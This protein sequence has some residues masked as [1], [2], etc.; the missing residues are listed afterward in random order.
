MLSDSE[1]R[2]VLISDRQRHLFAETDHLSICLDSD[3]SLFIKESSEVPDVAVSPRDLAYV[4]YT[5][6]STG[7][8]KGVMVTHGGLVN[9]VTWAAT[10]YSAGIGDSVPVHSSIAFDL[11]VTALWVPL[12]A[13]GRVELLADDVGGL[14]LLEALRRK[15]GRSLVKIT[16]AHLALLAE[17]LGPS[18]ASDLTNV[19]VIGGENLRAESLQRWR[20]E[21]PNTRLINEYG[22]TETVVGCCLYEVRRDDPRHGS[23]PIGRPI[24]NTQLYVLDSQMNPVPPG[25]MGELYIGG[26]GVARG[27]WNRRDLTEKKFVPDPFSGDTTARLYNSGDLARYRTDGTLEYLGRIDNQIKLRGFRIELGEIEAKLAEHPAVKSSA[28]LLHEVSDGNKQIFGY[29]VLRHQDTT[30]EELLVDLRKVLPEYMVP[31]Q[32][33]FLDSMPLTPNGKVD[34]TALSAGGYSLAVTTTDFVAPRNQLETSLASIWCEILGLSRVSCTENFFSLGGHSLSAM[35]VSAKAANRLRQEVPVR[36]IFEHPTIQ[37]LSKRMDQ[38][39]E[40]ERNDS[41]IQPVDR[42][43]QLPLSF[44]QL[45]MCLVHAILPDSATYNQPVAFRISGKA[46]QSRIRLTLLAIVRRHEVLRTTYQHCGGLFVQ[47]VADHGV[48]TLPWHEISLVAESPF[49]R[50]DILQKQILEEVRRPFDLLIAPLWRSIWFELTEIE[51]VLLFTFHHSIIDEWSLR[52]FVQEFSALYSCDGDSQRAKLP[53]LPIQYVDYANW[54]RQKLTGGHRERLLA[55]WKNQLADLPPALELPADRIRPLQ[56][57]GQGA[58]LEFHLDQLVV[59]GLRQLA[60]EEEMTLFTILLAGFQV[61]LYR[62]TGQTDIIVGTPLAD[63]ERPEVQSLIG[64]FLNMLP[65]RSRLESSTC[66]R[67]VLRDVHQTIRNAFSHADLPFEQMV[68]LAVKEREPGRNPIYQVM[69][70]LLEESIGDLK[71]GSLTGVPFNVHSRTT[72]NELTLDI[73]ATGDEWVCRMEY[74][75]ELFSA[76]AVN[77]MADHFTELLRS[78]SKTADTQIGQLKLMG[79]EERHRTLVEW[80]Q[81]RC[82]YP[83]EKCVHQLFEEQVQRTPHAV[84]IEFEGRLLTYGD[85]NARSNQLAHY[86]QKHGIS[87]ETRVGICVDR[88][89]EM[90]IGLL[91][92]L[93]AG[94]AYVPLDSHYPAERLNFLVSDTGIGTILTQRHLEN[95]WKNTDMQLVA[96]DSEDSVCSNEPDDNLNLAQS[97]ESSAYVIYTSGSTGTPKGVEVVH[98]GIVRLVCGADYVQLDESQSVLQLAVLSFDASTFEI[99]GPL[100]HGGRCVLAPAQ[101]PEPDELHE[102]LR[103][104]NVRTLFLTTA[105]FN[106]LVDGHFDAL[107]GIEQLLVGGE[108]LSVPHVR[109][110]Q[111]A[112]GSRTQLSNI[113]GPTESTTFACCHQLPA[114][115]PQDC[116]SIPIGR[117]I[118]NTTAYVLDSNLE[119]VPVGVTGELY[120]GGDGLALGYLNQPGLTAEKFLHDPFSDHPNARMYRTGDL[121]R[122]RADGTLEFLGRRDQQVKFRGFRIETGEVETVLL[123]HSAVTQT[124]VMLREDRPGE[125]RLVAYFLPRDPTSILPT[126][127]LRLFLKHHLP[128]YMLPSI[129]VQLS[130]LPLTVNGKVD[131]KGLPVPNYDLLGGKHRY[132]APRTPLEQI[133]ADAWK[134]V[135]G[136]ERLGVDDNFFELGGHSLLAMRVVSIIAK[137]LNREVLVK[138]VFENQTIQQLA[139]KLMGLEADKDQRQTIPLVDRQQPQPLSFGQYAMWLVQALLIDSATYNLPIAIRLRGRINRTVVDQCIE[140]IARRHESLRTA[141]VQSGETLVQNICEPAEFA[142]NR[143]EISLNV[144][145]TEQQEK[146]MQATLLDEVRRPF[147]L[148][149]APLWRVFWIELAEDDQVLV[150]TFHHGI[151]DEWSVRIFSNELSALYQTGGDPQAA[152]L[153]ELPIQYADFASWQ[154]VRQASVEWEQSLA[155]WKEQLADLPPALEL[156]TDRVRPIQPSG[157]GAVHEFRLTV[158]L[159]SQLR[160]L[161]RTESTTHFSLMLA[162]FHVWLA[163]HTGQTDIIVGTPVANRERPEVQSLIG[164]FLNTLPIRARIDGHLSFRSLLQQI[165]QTFWDAYTHAEIPFQR[166]VELTVKDRELGRHPIFQAMFI[167]L[168]ESFNDLKLGSSIGKPIEL[169]TKT[170]KNDL[171]LDIQATGDEW[172]C[173]MEYATDLFSPDAV[174]RMA[175]HFTELLQSIVK[176]TDVP[177]GRMKLM[178][179]EERHRI[180][181]EWNQTER[182][183]P[184]DKCL[185]QLFEEQV[186]RT[187]EAVAVEFEG[188]SLTYSELNARA[189]Q[190]ANYLRAQGVQPEMLVGVYAVR[191]LEMV[192]SLFGIL[193]AGGAY[194]PID[195]EYPAERVSYMLSDSGVSVLLTQSHLVASLPIHSATVLCLDTDWKSIS[196]LTDVNPDL[197]TTPSNLAYMIYTSGSTGKPKGATNS[198]RGIVNHMYWIQ[199]QYDLGPTDVVLQKTPFSFDVSVWEF[200]WPLL[201]GARLC[202]AKPGGH[203]DADYLVRFIQ[204]H[205]VTVVDFVPSMLQ[206]FLEHSDVERCT[207][208]RHVICIGEALPAD[209]RDRFFARLD[210]PLHNLYGPTEAAVAVTHWTCRREQTLPFVS[211]GRP[212]ANTQCYILDT[213]L[214]PVPIGVS[215]ELHL[216]GVQIGRGYHNQPELTAQKFIPDPFQSDPNARLYKTGD[217][218]R[219]LSDGNIQ[220]LGRI[221]NQVKIRGYRIELDE[222]ES[223]LASN[224][225]VSN[226]VVSADENKRGEKTL[227]AYLIPAENSVLSVGLLRKWLAGKLPDYMIPSRFFS[228]TAIPLSPNGKVDRRALKKLSALEL[229]TETEYQP[230][231]TNLEFQLT[232]IWQTVLGKERIGVHENFFELGGHSLLAV[233]VVDAIKSASGITIKVA[234]LFRHATVAELAETLSDSL[235]TAKV[236]NG[237]QYLETIRPG[238]QSTHLVIVGAKLRV[239]LEMLP[240]EIPVWWLKLDGLHVWPPKHLDLPTQAKIHAQ[241]LLHTIPSG[242]ILLCGHSYSGLLAIEVAEQ[243]KKSEKYDITLI[244]LE[245]SIPPDRDESIIERAT[246]KVLHYRKRIRFRLV[247]ELAAGLHNRTVGKLKNMMINA[248]QSAEQKIS[249]DDRWRY[250]A[251]FL[252]EHVRAYQLPDSI[253]HDVHLVKTDFYQTDFLATLN[254]ITTGALSIYSASESLDHLDI[255]KFRH[256]MIWMRI[257]QQLIA[258]RSN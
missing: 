59:T 4:M 132:I 240:P 138:W 248:R 159:T 24:A 207:T 103:Q 144:L 116:Q 15:K 43:G 164:Y 199:E 179:Q 27:Y 145:T 10:E 117:P 141:F 122:W 204:T 134:N 19:F 52:L 77:R 97:S 75:T 108:A 5:S 13:G 209:L 224:P 255:A 143:R 111:Q 54:Q 29:V 33:R 11:T 239:P 253:D 91:A 211:I 184:R 7:N 243:L 88:S 86:L 63:R 180:L 171:T 16:P 220:F 118:S 115:V 64:Y 235:G 65:I 21:A 9:Y 172:I 212:I 234:D 222:I 186:Q 197:K 12:I 95:R 73:Q 51:H 190:L 22:P 133:L 94:G 23:V 221:D 104:T 247:H 114:I 237:H 35:R 249:A 30:A 112:L 178:T 242:T 127:E 55:Y 216:G 102:L 157:E 196:S 110:A 25:V 83:R 45:G 241:E 194:V 169:P 79:Q 175:D 154:R 165:Q 98:R 189:N 26:A 44:G 78:I 258:E 252:F 181:V 1:A 251:P 162:V 203:K 192:V 191:S 20:D 69:F 147:D 89:L 119:P 125:K 193:K 195:P 57:T 227:E 213:H 74:A 90:I 60:R 238:N 257:V 236:S 126:D 85:L 129:F 82:D 206:L 39:S 233:R 214:E 185:H 202:V 130:N 177:I 128:E 218:C 136:I 142:V 256:S 72:K 120:L 107:K 137:Q 232:E 34:R 38:I 66:F 183:Y 250:M 87:P 2:I 168:E 156:P 123:R 155:Y 153:P 187:P 246:H 150:L 131:R 28:V 223:V 40:E 67:H 46:D 176:D 14:N 121:V 47:L 170:S 36:W 219:F 6:G 167:L 231:R 139:Q 158:S 113:Y 210:V 62:Y 166:L 68:E 225:D 198:H 18:E 81:T 228:I 8:P 50:N 208:L 140:Q 76:E 200:F 101:F 56:P 3:P 61:W 146:A 230:P 42:H 217:L 226:C 152:L 49:Q 70:V 124:V 31:S 32:L 188:Q 160:Q 182:D 244:L 174:D 163:R 229:E 106:T 148:A 37:D 48:L 41:S 53:D 149:V 215:G 173:R 205:H 151:I 161:A 254:Q 96:L 109:R 92:I 17:Q 71:L 201:N 58:I 100:L 105:L 93:K 80:N 84:A 245:P 99:W 135:L